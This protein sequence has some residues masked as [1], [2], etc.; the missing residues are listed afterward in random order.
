MW[1]ADDG[2]IARPNPSGFAAR[3]PLAGITALADRRSRAIGRDEVPLPRHASLTPHPC[4]SLRQSLPF[5]RAVRLASLGRST[6]LAITVTT[7]ITAGFAL[8]TPAQAERASAVEVAM[9]TDLAGRVERQPQAITHWAAVALDEGIALFDA[10]RTWERSTAELRFVDGTVVMLDEKTR[11]RISPVLF[12]PAQAPE[13]VRLAL[14]EGSAEVRAGTARLWV[15]TPDGMRHAVAPGEAVRI[16]VGD[17]P[18][19]PRVGPPTELMPADLERGPMPAP[20]DGPGAGAGSAFDPTTGRVDP[21]APVEGL[22]EGLP[23]TI[24]VEIDP[25]ADGVVIQLPIGDGPE[26]PEPE[27]PDPELPDPEMPPDPPVPTLPDLV[28]GAAILNDLLPDGILP[29]LD[30]PDLPTDGRVRVSVEVRRR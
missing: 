5:G 7:V 13:E 6:L 1:I 19:L 12:D 3:R 23:G 18:H 22:V 26:L 29:V 16:S 17:G 11:L 4:L 27:L 14:A 10:M 9:V 28:P 15:D 21:T 25:S 30:L 20:S 2:R 24:G 8:P